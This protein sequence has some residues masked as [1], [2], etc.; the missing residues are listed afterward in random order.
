MKKKTKII[1]AISIP[2]GVIALTISAFFIYVSVGQ[3]KAGDK[4]ITALNSKEVE[5][6][7]NNDYIF[8]NG[9]GSKDALILYPGAKVESKAYSPL[10]LSIAKSGTDVFILECPFNIALFSQYKYKDVIKD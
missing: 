1:L 8:F 4:A 2:V 9:S 10:A 5:I 3:Y 7:Q 6:T